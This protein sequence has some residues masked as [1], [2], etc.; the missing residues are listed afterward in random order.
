MPA[1]ELTP[2]QYV[3][4]RL[5]RSSYYRRNFAMRPYISTTDGIDYGPRLL[6]ESEVIDEF[7]RNGVGNLRVDQV[8]LI[9]DA[10]AEPETPARLASSDK[11]RAAWDQQIRD[12]I[13]QLRVEQVRKR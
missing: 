10:L 6:R 2:E 1:P 13:N 4:D 8:Q 5:R 7:L 3:Q 12:T 9:M 11:L